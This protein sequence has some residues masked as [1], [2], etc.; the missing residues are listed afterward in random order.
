MNMYIFENVDVVSNNWHSDG[1]LAIV[2]EDFE[3][4]LRLVKKECIIKIAKSQN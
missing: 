1:G 2:A 4:V 3:H